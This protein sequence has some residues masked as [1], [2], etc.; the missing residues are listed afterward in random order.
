M[1]PEII[2]NT[3]LH[4]SEIICFLSKPGTQ[5]LEDIQ[6]RIKKYEMTLIYQ[7]NQ[8]EKMADIKIVNS[9]DNLLPT[10]ISYNVIFKNSIN[11]LLTCGKT[12]TIISFIRW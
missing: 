8:K 10:A 9:L 2:I 4:S 6:D 12:I 5:H 1:V 7:K 3:S 11:L